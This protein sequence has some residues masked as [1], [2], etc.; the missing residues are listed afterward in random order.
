MGEVGN[1]GNSA[2]FF[3]FGRA[4]LGPHKAINLSGQG[5][6]LRGRLSRIAGTYDKEGRDGF[7]FGQEAF[8]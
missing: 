8:K 7:P 1:D 2:G 3:K 4:F 6:L 5:K